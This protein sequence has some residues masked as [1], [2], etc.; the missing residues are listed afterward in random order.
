M[1][2]S[3]SLQPY[4]FTVVHHLGKDN[5]NADVLSRYDCSDKNNSS[6]RNPETFEQAEY[7]QTSLILEEGE[8]CGRENDFIR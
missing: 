1:R 2:W 5:H 7:E 4:D 8:E 6:Q 3:L